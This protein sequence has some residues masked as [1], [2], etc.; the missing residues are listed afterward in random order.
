MPRASGRDDDAAPPRLVRDGD[1]MHY[2]A[3]INQHIGRNAHEDRPFAS[4]RWPS[5]CVLSS[6]ALADD[7]IAKI[8]VLNDQSSLYADAGGPGS[9]ARGANGGRGQRPDRTR[10]GRSTSSSGDHLNKPDVGAG[11]AR[12]WFD[13]DKVDVDR[14]R[15]EFRR[16]ARRRGRREGKERRVPEFGRRHFGS[17]RQGL[18][19]QHRSIG[20]TTPTR[21]PTARARRSSRPAATPGSSSPP[22]TP[23][24]RR[25]SATPP[26]SSRPTAARWSAAS[27]CRSTR[28]TSPPSCCRRKPR[29]PRSSASPTPAATRQFDQAGA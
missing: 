1:T 10:A 19:A 13:E 21:S 15:A 17:D 24:A 7:K 22:T 6:A 5:A 29:R 16:R 12:K 11:I 28:P 9:I 25:C 8:G 26:R 4:R 14:R 18:H 23:S 3:A 2:D 20:P 27:T